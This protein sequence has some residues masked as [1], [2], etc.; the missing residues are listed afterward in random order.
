MASPEG[1]ASRGARVVAGLVTVILL[2]GRGCGV[3]LDDH[4]DRV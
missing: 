3:T 4:A 2:S 1:M